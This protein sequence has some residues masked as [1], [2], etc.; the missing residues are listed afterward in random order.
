MSPQVDAETGAV[1]SIS[2]GE[3]VWAGQ[4]VS[5]NH[6]AQRLHDAVLQGNAVTKIVADRDG[7]AVTVEVKGRAAGGV[8]AVVTVVTVVVYRPR[9]LDE[10]DRARNIQT[11]VAVVASGAGVQLY[12][13]A[14]GDVDSISG[15][16]GDVHSV[17]KQVLHAV[18][19]QVALEIG[20]LS[21]GRANPEII[22]PGDGYVFATATCDP[23]SCSV[24]K[25]REHGINRGIGAG[26]VAGTI[27]Y[28][29]AKGAGRNEKHESYCQESDKEPANS[30]RSHRSLLQLDL[31][32]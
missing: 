19:G 31:W 15:G 2:K 24:G 12:T 23:H 21:P 26:C 3:T 13:E 22:Q 5:D 11:K 20:G 10:Y 9:V 32:V 18:D 6:V 16:V 14:I 1:G 8:D 7:S 28:V 4:V 29:L 17:K 27:D 25:K 30:C